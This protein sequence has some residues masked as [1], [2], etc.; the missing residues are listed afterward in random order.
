MENAGHDRWRCTQTGLILT[1]TPKV[2]LWRVFAKRHGLMNPPPRNGEPELNWGRFDVS[3]IATIYGA[4]N[5]R[6]AFVEALSSFTPA[7]IDVQELFDDIAPG[8][9]PIAEDWKNSQHMPP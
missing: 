1:I 9:D 5:S 7:R 6:G 3:G 8:Q 2:A 4:M